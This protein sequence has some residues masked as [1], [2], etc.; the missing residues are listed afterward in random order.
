MSPTL[1]LLWMLNILSDTVG[2]LA[3]KAGTQ[4][5]RTH[6]GA[7]YLLEVM[8]NRWIWLGIGCYLF[9]F[10]LWLGFLSLV[11]LSDGVLLGSINIVAVMLAGRVFFGERLIPYKLV[12]IALVS[13]GVALVGAD[14]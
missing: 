4:A 8:R 7:R 10:F 2:Q 13:G 6:E 9:E 1:L 12:G 5:E 3:F 14:L 11:P